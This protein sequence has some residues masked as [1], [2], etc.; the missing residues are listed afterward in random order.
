MRK[1]NKKKIIE[2]NKKFGGSLINDSNLDFDIESANQEKNIFKSNAKLL[3][4]IVSGHPFS[5]GNKRTAIS[6]VSK[7]L[8]EEDIKIDKKVMAKGVVDIAKKNITDLN[9]IE[10]K[11][12]KWSMKK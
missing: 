10:K 7:R 1:I 9:K 12:R 4:G 8:A 11:L 5:D 6:E 3:R 2:L